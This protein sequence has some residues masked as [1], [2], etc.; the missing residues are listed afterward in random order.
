MSL[1]LPPFRR[2][3]RGFYEIAAALELKKALSQTLTRTFQAGGSRR[4]WTLSYWERRS[5]AGFGIDS[6]DTVFLSGSSYIGHR[7][8]AS[9]GYETLEYYDGSVYIASTPVFRD[10]SSFLHFVI[11]W[12]SEN[13]TQADRMR[14][15]VNGVRITSFIRSSLPGLNADSAFNAAAAHEIGRYSSTYFDGVLADL[16]F[17]DG[18]ALDASHFGGFDAN[19]KWHPKKYAGTYGVTGFRL[20]FANSG[21]L[22]ADVSGNG[23]NWTP[24]ASPVQTLDTPTNVYARLDPT[25][26]NGSSAP[27]L[28]N[29]GLTVTGG[30]M[31]KAGMA[32]PDGDWYWEVKLDTYSGV[33]PFGIATEGAST[34]TYVGQDANSWGYQPDGQKRTAGVASAYGT[35][36][37][38][39]QQLC[40]AVRCV[41]GSLAIWFGKISGGVTTWQNSGDPVA[42]TNPAFSGVTGTILPAVSTQGTGKWS[43]NFGQSAFAGTPP[44][45]FKTLCTKNLPKPAIAD[46]GNHFDIALYTGNGQARPIPTEC[47]P[48]LVWIKSRG[49]ATTHAVYDVLRG[50]LAFLRT[51]ATSSEQT[52]GSDGVTEFLSNGFSLGVAAGIG[53]N[54]LNDPV[55]AWVWGGFTQMAAPEIAALVAATGATITPT[56]IAVNAAAGMAIITWTGNG[57]AG[58]LPHPLGKKPGMFVVKDRNAANCNWPVYHES[59]GA[60]KRGCLNL[61]NTFDAQ[62]TWW[63]N[64]EPTTGLITLGTGGGLQVNNSTYVMYVFAPVY[65]FSAFG[66]YVG[67][68]AA[69]G[70]RIIL[71]FR[72][73]WTLIKSSTVG[74]TAWRIHDDAR[75]ACNPM[76]RELVPNTSG[77]ENGIG[78]AQEIDFLANGFKIRA[79]DTDLNSGTL[80]YAAF[81]RYPF[82]GGFVAP[83]PAR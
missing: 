63:Q 7:Y 23:N 2:P 12:D 39:G 55:V 61:T 5:G 40:V 30:Q 65:G 41:A 80:I 53:V 18:A 21:S 31:V 38:T 45:G 6:S 75:D 11:V 68:V 9:P 47:A 72:P 37:T 70:P 69:D 4:K 16:H 81:A 49:A 28:S 13:A 19:G 54:Q 74:T 36:F 35:S 57:T 73:A 10:T 24:Q 44:S 79:G 14:M 78:S 64:T 25:S 77:A 58:T 27:T 3:R 56:G 15:Y 1:V 66:S 76:F 59:Q 8:A 62:P 26:K 32:I 52:S 34:D 46:P 43:L 83:V 71:P 22:G 29:A 20:D 33:H 42:G 67:N 82:G 17:V 60:T 48:G 51:Q 50:P